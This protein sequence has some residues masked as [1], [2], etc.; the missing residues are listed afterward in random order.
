MQGRNIKIRETPVA[1]INDYLYEKKIPY[2]VLTNYREFVLFKRE[3]GYT[4][5]HKIDFLEINLE[6][7]IKKLMF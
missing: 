3:E 7:M 1:Q 2:G 6:K 4:K 5:Y